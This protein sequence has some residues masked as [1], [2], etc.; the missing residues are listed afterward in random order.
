MNK[1]EKD[2]VFNEIMRHLSTHGRGGDF[3]SY[4]AGRVDALVEFLR[5]AG[6]YRQFLKWRA[7]QCK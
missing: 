1:L 2:W 4:T 5:N 7:K 6:Y 3:G